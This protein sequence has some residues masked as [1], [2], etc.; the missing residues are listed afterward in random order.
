MIKNIILVLVLAI[1][2]ILTYKQFNK[3]APPKP[4]V[5]QKAVKIEKG[6][7]LGTVYA[8]EKL[9]V[10]LEVK[11][12][13]EC[14]VGDMDVMTKDLYHKKQKDF[15]IEVRSYLDDKLSISKR[16][17]LKELV[18]ARSMD[19]SFD[20]SNFKGKHAVKLSIC[21]TFK[22]GDSCGPAQYG[23]IMDLFSVYVDETIIT[24]PKN[25]KEKGKIRQKN[26]RIGSFEK[27]VI[28]T[29]FLYNFQYFYLM[30]GYIKYLS[31]YSDKG[32]FY[33]ILGIYENEFNELK[34]TYQARLQNMYEIN[35][36]LKSLPFK[37]ED[38]KF[39]IGLP[40]RDRSC[41]VK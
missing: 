40:Y 17:N 9:N 33:K 37:H 2:S 8:G 32:K 36:T 27:E 10:K 35:T 38:G 18:E 19:I 12:H 16:V 29:D 26:K 41:I 11:K 24:N 34:A 21:S 30:D 14:W 28:A 6:L 13:K 3:K 4:V 39:V 7:R 1:A 23:D 31:T 25:P 20:M 5:S 15:L 22:G